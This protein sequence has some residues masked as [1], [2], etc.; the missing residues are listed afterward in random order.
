LTRE[1]EL[2]AEAVAEISQAK[3]EFFGIV[4]IIAGITVFVVFAGDENMRTQLRSPLGLVFLVGGIANF[5]LG[6][7]RSLRIFARAKGVA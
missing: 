3:G 5:G 6:I 2:Q 7:R 4:G 1:Q